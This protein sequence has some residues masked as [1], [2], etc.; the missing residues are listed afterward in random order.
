MLI[1]SCLRIHWMVFPVSLTPYIMRRST[2]TINFTTKDFGNLFI[3]SCE[4]PLPITTFV[5]NAVLRPR[6]TEKKKIIVPL[7]IGHTESRFHLPAASCGLKTSFSTCTFIGMHVM[8]V[9]WTLLRPNNSLDQTHWHVFEP[10]TIWRIHLLITI[11]ERP[12]NIFKCRMC[13]FETGTDNQ[14]VYRN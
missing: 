4:K 5:V 2:L 13:Y 12:L 11:M 14:H 3:R 6:T 9:V 7:G 8:W 1:G 10:I